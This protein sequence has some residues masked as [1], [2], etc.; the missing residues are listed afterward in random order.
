MTLHVPEEEMN[1]V[2]MD[3]PMS[4]FL[5]RAQKKKKKKRSF[6]NLL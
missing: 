1:D 3:A 4:S 2:D 6:K 5:K